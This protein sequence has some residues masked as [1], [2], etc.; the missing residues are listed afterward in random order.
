MENEFVTFTCNNDIH[1]Y[2]K[3]SGVKPMLPYKKH[4]SEEDAVKYLK[5]TRGILD[6][7]IIKK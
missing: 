1:V 5:E 6:P 2:D 4:S 3:T 7:K